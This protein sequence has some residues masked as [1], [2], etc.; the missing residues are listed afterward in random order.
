MSRNP[1]KKNHLVQRPTSASPLLF[2]AED[3]ELDHVVQRLI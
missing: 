2:H 3:K 1:L